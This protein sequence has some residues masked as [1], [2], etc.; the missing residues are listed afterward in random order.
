MDTTIKPSEHHQNS[1]RDIEEGALQ[2]D[3]IS[4]AKFAVVPDVVMDLGTDDFTD[5]A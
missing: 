5:Q 3:A 2:A 1:E 4:V